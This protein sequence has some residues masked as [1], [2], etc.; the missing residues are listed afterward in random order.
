MLVKGIKDEDF[1]NYQKPSLFI[2]FP[3]CSFKCDKENGAQYCQNMP[4]TAQPN[5]EVNVHHLVKRYLSNPITKA[6]VC[7][8]L[9]P[10]DSWHE[11]WMFVW[12][13]REVY[14][15]EDDIVIYTGYEPDE[16][17]EQADA[18]RA[19][20]NIIVKWGRFRPNQRP[21]F[22]AVLGI[23]LASDNQRAERLEIKE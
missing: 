22:D 9:E 4:L 12:T 11:L 17:P 2:A 5:I 3:N 15:C 19:F 20:P 18:L 10:I 21:H 1:V 13:V 23:N 7:G 8:G 14:H 16:M 6:I